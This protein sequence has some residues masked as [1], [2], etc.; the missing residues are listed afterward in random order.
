MITHTHNTRTMYS[1]IG[2]HTQIHLLHLDFRTAEVG[3]KFEELQALFEVQRR[4]LTTQLRN[5]DDDDTDLL[6]GSFVHGSDKVRR[7]SEADMHG[8]CEVSVSYEALNSRR[9]YTYTISSAPNFKI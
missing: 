1:R 3:R 7:K 4:S 6:R 2:L 5:H 8:G 9:A